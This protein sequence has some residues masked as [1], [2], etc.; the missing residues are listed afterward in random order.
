MAYNFSIILFEKVLRL[1]N[2]GNSTEDIIEETIPKRRIEENITNEYVGY[3]EMASKKHNQ[4]VYQ[5]WL[6]IVIQNERAVLNDKKSTIQRILGTSEEITLDWKD[7][8][9]EGLEKIMIRK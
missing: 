7:A 5:I 3:C 8:I 9:K 1:V 2:D 4:W 6:M